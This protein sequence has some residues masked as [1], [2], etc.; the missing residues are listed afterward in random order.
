MLILWI[1]IKKGNSFVRRIIK[2]PITPGEMLKEEFLIPLKLTQ[3]HFANHIGVDTK[4]INRVVKGRTAL[5]PEL[6]VKFAA[7]FSMNAEFWLNLQHA[8]DLWKIHKSGKNLPKP[9][10]KAS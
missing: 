3:R 6:A 4:T 1:A 5:T 9:L 7:A 8:V 2:N 10:I